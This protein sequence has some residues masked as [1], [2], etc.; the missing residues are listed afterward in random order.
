MAA[1]TRISILSTCRQ[2][3]LWLFFG[4][5]YDYWPPT[6]THRRT[7]PIVKR[8]EQ[9]D[10][11]S[12]TTTHRRTLP[13]VKWTEQYDYWPP[14]AHCIYLY[15]RCNQHIKAHP[16]IALAPSRAC[17]FDIDLWIGFLVASGV[18]TDSCPLSTERRTSSSSR[19]ANVCAL[20]LHPIILRFVSRSLSSAI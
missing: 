16:Q 9:Y 7:L 6:T 12:P 3:V 17:P 14:V 4:G 13:I 11:W 1:H 10:Y 8:T 18:Q 19:A 2:Y 20:S 15:T 5:W